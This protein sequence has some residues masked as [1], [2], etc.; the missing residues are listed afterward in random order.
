MTTPP[1]AGPPAPTVTFWGAAQQVTGSM[2]LVEA[3]GHRILLDCGLFLGSRS[4]TYARN[5]AF[6][7]RPAELDAVVLSHAHID[8]CGN[9]PNLIRQGF[10]G[11]VFCTPATYDLLGLML[12]D[13]A[14]I[15]EEDALVQRV[16]EQSGQEAL[17]TREDAARTLGQCVAV[18]YD[19]PHA[20]NAY[21]E[22]RFADAGHILGSAMVGLA[23]DGGGREWSLTFT[24]D[25]G[26]RGQGFLREP[27]AVPRADL[28]ICESTYAGRRHE[29]LTQTLAA[30]ADTVR[31]TVARGGKVFIPAF[32][33]GR[34][35]IVVHYLRE[36]VRSGRLPRV[37]LFVDSP[38]AADIAEVYRRHPDCL[39]GPPEVGPTAEELVHYVRTR[40]ES[41]EV[42]R[43]RDPCVVV[44]SGGMCQ[45]GRILHHLQHHIDDPRC[46][47]VL[48]SYQALQSLGHRLL[49]RGPTVRFLGRKWNKWAEVVELTG[50]SGH[51][52]HADFLAALAPL[53]GRT[54]KVR[55]VHGEPAQAEAL[56]RDLRERGFPD[57]AI[58][59]R[60]ESV[61]IG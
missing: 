4:E 60:G 15:H 26:R 32:S 44:A 14:R 17:Y 57:I 27:A 48:V 47:V 61:A 18:P 25:L 24:G 16:L 43:Q 38:L 13:S 12:A 28:L 51:A 39:A 9:L 56:A 58:P 22:L 54:P 5:R 36:G 46:T 37:P 59:G 45:G 35:Q 34:A 6:P 33:L 42:S 29:P 30:L 10:T 41:R 20:L 50:F 55:L 23:L 49:E 3:A 52:D 7:F 21:A 31:R 19:R 8:H 11:P 53:A 40:E 1:L 2:H